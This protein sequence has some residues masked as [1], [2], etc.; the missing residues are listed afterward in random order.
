MVKGSPTVRPQALKISDKAEAAEQ[1][2]VQNI[3]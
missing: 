1:E 3:T 2:E